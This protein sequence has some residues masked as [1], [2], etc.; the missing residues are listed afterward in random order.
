MSCIKRGDTASCVYSTNAQVRHHR[1]YSS[2]PKTSEAQL[3]LQKLE[4]VVASLLR[5]SSNGSE[6][7]TNHESLDDDAVN[8]LKSLSVDNPPQKPNLTIQGHLDHRGSETNYHGATHWAT[9][10]E[11]VC[12]PCAKSPWP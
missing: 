6:R 4:E 7:L 9:I 1:P 10:L 8:Q 5:T 3:R 2:G 11:N 12:H